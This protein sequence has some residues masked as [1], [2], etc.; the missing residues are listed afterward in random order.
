[1]ASRLLFYLLCALIL[2]NCKKEKVE[3]YSV[4]HTLTVD[5]TDGGTVNSVGGNYSAGAEVR[6]IATPNNYYQFTGWSNGST[7]N[8][9]VLTINRDI[10][11]V[12]NFVK[13]NFSLNVLITGEGNVEEQ[14]IASGKGTD[15]T[16]ESQIR[17]TANALEGWE[18]SSWSGDQNSNE[19]PIEVTLNST[20]TIM[21]TFVENADEIET[22]ENQGIILAADGQGD[23]YALITSVLAPGYNP[24]ETP[25]CNHTEFGNHIDEVYDEI[26]QK[27]VFQFHIHPTPDNDRCINFDRQRNEIKTY[28]QSP[29]N[30]LG[31]E[32]ETVIYT[33]KFKL[34]EGFQSSPKFTHI[35]QLKSVGG[36]YSSMPMYTLTTR[37]SNP[38]R[39]ELR[40]AETDQQITLKQ[41]DLAP[42]IN[43]W[44]TVSQT[45]QYSTNG[46]YTIELTDVISGASLFTYTNE[47]SIN[48]R[49]AAEFVRPK[50]GVYRSLIY[51]E[52]LRDEI[53]RFADFQIIEMP[54]KKA[55]ADH[56]GL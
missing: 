33:W 16:A 52:D 21:A 5:G 10:N 15:Y 28:D 4:T 8:P 13:K 38:D 12:A 55:H 31:S 14:I 54:Y 30:L 53:V 6:L 45:I 47:N 39:L 26:L 48:W 42:L 19:N 43:R 37:K 7:E 22:S 36:N 35:H 20:K 34:A 25:D 40:Y 3:P 1:M 51:S 41:T 24:I 29:E 23:T 17:L 2:S 9:L 11:L 44:I 18:F 46:H 32:N 27:H 50:W 56:V 49:P